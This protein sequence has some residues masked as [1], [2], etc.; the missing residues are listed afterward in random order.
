M[1]KPKPPASLEAAGKAFWG[2]VISKYDLRV[3]ELDCRDGHLQLPERP[4]IKRNELHPENRN[5]NV[6]RHLH[7]I[8]TKCGSLAAHTHKLRM[9]A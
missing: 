2:E 7:P 5:D 9:P 6:D 8:R 3:D 1:S 4:D